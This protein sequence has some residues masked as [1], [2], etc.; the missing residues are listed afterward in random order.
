MKIPKPVKTANGTYRIQLR[1]GGKSIAVTGI[2][3]AEC[4]REAVAVKAAHLTGRNTQ[5]RCT[6]TTAEAIDKYIAEHT[7]LSPSTVRGYV[8]IRDN[9]FRSARDKIVDSVD[10][11]RVIDSDPHAP[12]TII[13]AWGFISTVMRYNGVQPPD[14]TLPQR[15]H[16][17]RPF[18]DEAQIKTFLNAVHGLRCETAA[19]LG[20]HS[21]RRSEILGLTWQDVDIKRN[22][23]H[24]R[25]A[26]VLDRDGN[27]VRKPTTK[28]PSSTRDVP[29]MIP[30]LAE[31]L[32]VGGTG[33]IITA[34]P[35]S[36]YKEINAACAKAGLPQVGVHGLRHSF[37]SLAYHLG[38][39]ELA[40]MRVAGY[41]DYNTMRKIYTHL[42]ESDRQKDVSAMT[43]F[44]ASNP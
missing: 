38:W 16:T 40:T 8:S 27:L 23:I 36:L 22:V 15:I 41:A 39:S 29:I 25:G 12:K 17:D 1:L 2:T 7:R 21:L 9:V 32:S 20:L 28:N 13:N 24:V 3:A 10:W 31:L 26:A 4:K 30:R 37:V 14:V 35:N 34:Y 33:A 44:F 6:I 42:A 18:L 5:R 43:D 19:L 11:Q